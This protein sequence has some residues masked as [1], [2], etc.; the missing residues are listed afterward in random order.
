MKPPRS[1]L[2]RSLRALAVF[3]TLAAT[4]CAAEIAVCAAA[5]LSDALGEL[6][7]LFREK[8]GHSVRLNLGASGTLARQIAAGAPAD[9]FISADEARM[10]MLETK[11]LLMPHTRR[12]VLSNRL[13]VIVP[14]KTKSDASEPGAIVALADLR[15]PAVRRIAIGET[16]TVPAGT[17]AKT[18]LE[19]TGAWEGLQGKLIPLGS[20]R[21]VLAAVEAGNADAAFVYRTDALSSRRVRIAFT[22]DS[23]AALRISYPAAVLRTAKHREASLQLLDFLGGVQALTVF[24]RHGFSVANPE[25]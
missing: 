19:T 4:A 17:Y 2:H 8:T 18:F 16:A 14:T 21:A 7:A 24:E 1:T 11:G 22:I 23:G 13:V 20:A 9:L 6:A 15:K 3:W 12:T 25:K 5:S 10:D